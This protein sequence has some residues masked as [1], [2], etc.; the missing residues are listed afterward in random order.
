MITEGEFFRAL[1]EV[2]KTR[3][4]LVWEDQG[5]LLTTKF[6]LDEQEY[7]ISIRE[8]SFN[9]VIFYEISFTANNSESRTHA[10]TN[11]NKNQFKILG[12]VSNGIKEKIIGANLVY[13]TAKAYTSNSDIEYKSK[14]KLYSRLAHKMAVELNMYETV[15]SLGDETVFI[16]AKSQQLLNTAVQAI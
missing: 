3:Q 11:F 12:I 10:A 16:I 5:G 4:D 15:K 13:F 6:I 7:G 2:F 9:G 1:M 14:V 8:D